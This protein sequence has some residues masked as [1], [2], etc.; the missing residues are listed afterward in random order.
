M[1]PSTALQIALLAGVLA[2]LVGAATGDSL[3][4]TSNKSEGAVTPLIAGDENQGR[5]SGELPTPVNMGRATVDSSP[6]R[7]PV[8]APSE[9]APNVHQ[10]RS[11]A[12]GPSTSTC[13]CSL[14]IVRLKKR[15]KWLEHELAVAGSTRGGPVGRWLAELPEDLRPGEDTVRRLAEH[16]EAYPV[17]LSEQEGLWVS[18]R[19]EAKDW[20]NW[21][22]TIDEALI[23]YLGPD[24]LVRELPEEAL[25]SLR[26]EWREEGLF[27]E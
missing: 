5:L 24:R 22:P 13:T 12:A 10:G 8:A 1:R 9:D 17:E 18:E 15:V 7:T 4:V 16:M 19:I 3:L 14:E 25:A 23:V 21:G 6:S 11:V 20:K 27:P 2:F 26:E